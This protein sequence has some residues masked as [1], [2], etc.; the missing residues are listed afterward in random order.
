MKK[1]T[2]FFAIFSVPSLS[3]AH[4]PPSDLALGI[5]FL[6]IAIWIALLCSTIWGYVLLARKKQPKVFLISCSC[7]VVWGILLY[8]DLIERAFES[9]Y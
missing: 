9:V 2:L 7:W 3:Y 8:F 5:S 1:A 4:G 6:Y